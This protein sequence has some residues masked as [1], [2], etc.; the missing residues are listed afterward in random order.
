MTSQLSHFPFVEPKLSLPPQHPAQRRKPFS[1]D[2][3]HHGYAFHISE[4]GG[5]RNKGRVAR[6]RGGAFCLCFARSLSSATTKLSRTSGSL[7]LF[8]FFKIN[9][10]HPPSSQP[11]NPRRPPTECTAATWPPWAVPS[12]LVSP[13]SGW[14]SP[15]SALSCS[16]RVW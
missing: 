9:K 1:Q 15:L 14:S 5:R 16:S 12:P 13:S 6:S 8:P 11:T 7:T 2:P 3:R 4:A 10:T